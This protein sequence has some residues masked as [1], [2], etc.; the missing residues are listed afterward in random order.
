MDYYIPVSD[1][2]Y[3]HSGYGYTKSEMTDIIYNCIR[4]GDL[5][6]LKVLYNEGYIVVTLLYVSRA[7]KYGHYHVADWLLTKLKNRYNC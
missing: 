3:V 7:R 1:R 2:Y 6:K 5:E 4:Y